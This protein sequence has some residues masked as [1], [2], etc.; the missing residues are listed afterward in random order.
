MENER[1][2]PVG[3]VPSAVSPFPSDFVN[4]LDNLTRYE[5]FLTPP[6]ADAA[7]AYCI[8]LANLHIDFARM[9]DLLDRFWGVLDLESR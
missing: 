4:L 6:V 9:A 8:E 7:G 5:S 3:L 2:D 1:L